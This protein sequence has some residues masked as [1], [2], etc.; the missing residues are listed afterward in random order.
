MSKRPHA[1]S[2]APSPTPF[3]EL[4]AVLATLAEG[5]RERLGDNFAGAWLQGSFAVGDADLSS[6]VDFI[7]GVRRDLGAGEVE[8]LDALHEAIFAMPVEPWRH[9][10]EGSYVPLDHLRA[11]TP[12]PRDPPDEARGPD[13]RDPCLAGQGPERY[14]FWHLPHGAPKLVR[15]EHG[16]TRV[17]RWCLREK[18]VTLAGANPRRVVDPVDTAALRAEVQA[19]MGV[20][21]A[22]G[23]QPMATIFHQA[24]F[25][26]LYCRM[27]H[28]LATGRVGSKKAGAEWA[29]AHL[30]PRWRELIVR[31]QA[32]RQWDEPRR[33]APPDPADVEATHAFAAWAVAF[34]QAEAQKRREALQ[35]PQ[36]RQGDP[37]PPGRGGPPGAAGRPLQSS[38]FTPP[39]MRP[40]RGHRG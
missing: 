2:G 9:R 37:A 31:S 5:A 16:N 25:V 11:Q 38:K 19:N 14:P 12:A 32:E 17:V 33:L 13:W 30:D 23:L 39:P 8:R 40:G 20:Y 34:A 7:V 36:G 35:P 6:D 21:L 1:R 26:V 22:R 18:G 15:S 29:A 10:L 28:T 4:D 27:L 24:F 3:P